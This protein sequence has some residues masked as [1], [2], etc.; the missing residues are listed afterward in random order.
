MWKSGHKNAKVLHTQQ[1]KRQYEKE[2]IKIDKL[3]KIECK[4]VQK[5]SKTVKPLCA[6]IQKK[7]EPVGWSPAVKTGKQSLNMSN[8]KR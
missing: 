5:S 8:N 6:N 3:N 4:L 1:R 2:E 7:A